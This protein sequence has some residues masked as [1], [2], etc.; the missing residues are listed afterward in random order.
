MDREEFFLTAEYFIRLLRAGLGAENDPFEK[1]EKVSWENVFNLAEKH[2]VTA[3]A[4]TGLKKSL[5]SPEGEMLEKWKRAYH[6]CVHAD[7]TQLFSWEEI[8]EA[9]TEK[10][11]KILP[12]KGLWIKPLY[13]ETQLRQMADLDILYEEKLLPK[14]KK[15]MKSL[16]YTYEKLSAGGVHQ[17]FQRPPVMDVE[18]HRQLLSEGVPFAYY[19]DDPWARALPTEEPFVYRF[20]D[21]DKYLF[22]LIH[23]YKH[24]FGA[25]SGARTVA[26]FYVFFEKCGAALDRAWIA[27]EI[28]KADA[29]AR[30]NG[31]DGNPLADFEALIK[32]QVEN[33]F[34]GEEITI[35]ETGLEILSDGVYGHI[36]KLWNRGIAEHGGKK[37]FLQRLFPPF[38]QL[39]LRFP[40]L[41]KLPFLAPFF[42]IWR[43][44]YAFTHHPKGLVREYRYVKK[45]SG[46]QQKTKDE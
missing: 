3:L 7:T 18:M 39:R 33:W 10:E 6:I 45:N 4:Y 9:L 28:A 30:E 11:V 34:G 27:E 40:I 5:S 14:V 44:V 8:K 36:E 37:Y 41:K 32:K 2:S 15:A 23:D 17:V 24:F 1:P 13:P 29:V 26:D 38:K 43:I 46:K 12:L 35:D 20:S 31:A 42:W 19:Y 22:M 25:G 21:E 16:G